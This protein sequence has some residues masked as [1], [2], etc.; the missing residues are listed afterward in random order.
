MRFGFIV[1]AIALLAGVALI[2]Q[3]VLDGGANVTLIVII[4]I[5]SGY[6]LFF[7]LGVVLLFVGFLSLPFAFASDDP[8]LPLTPPGAADSSPKASGGVGGFVL[9]GPVPILF[10]NWKG[11]SRRTQAWLVVVGAVLFIAA[12]VGFVLFVR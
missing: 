2:V 10:G 7:L 6:S 5:I 11:V 1:S 4:P 12:I 8:E 9:I 3:S